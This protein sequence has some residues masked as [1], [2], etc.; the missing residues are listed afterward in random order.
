MLDFARPDR[1]STIP[2]DNG[3]LWSF[4]LCIGKAQEVDMSELVMRMLGLKSYV[5]G[6][7]AMA[8]RLHK[9][10]VNNISVVGRGAVVVHSE[11]SE[12]I[13][14]YREAAKRFVEQDASAVA[15]G[16]KDSDE[17]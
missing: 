7:Q 5:A 13:S 4:A 10:G 12:K 1:G 16:S 14:R 6:G 17:Q 9:S 2:N 3:C 11:D 8:D 15:A